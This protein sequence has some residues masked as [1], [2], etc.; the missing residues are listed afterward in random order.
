MHYLYILKSLKCEANYTGITKH[1]EKRLSEHNSGRVKST[2]CYSPWAIIYSK[3][4]TTLSEAKK[5]EWFF[6]CTPQGGKLK[7]KILKMAV[8]P[9]Q[10]A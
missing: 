8:I 1:L 7:K 2:K 3:K 9:A 10:S 6:K 4:F 5:C